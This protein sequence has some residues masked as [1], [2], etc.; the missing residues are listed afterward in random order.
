MKTDV[1]TGV[2]APFDFSGIHEEFPSLREQDIDIEVVPFEPI[3]SS[4]ASPAL[5]V[6][7]AE[8]IKVSYDR[9]DGFV[10]LHGTDT[11]SY[12]SSALGFMLENLTKPVVFTGSQ[13]PI[14][15]MRTDGRENLITAIEIAAAK[16]NKG[17]AMVPEV[18]LYF[19][20]KLFRAN[21]TMKLSAEDLS[22]FASY[23][24]PALADVGI[25]IHYNR[26]AIAKLRGKQPFGINTAL[27][28]RVMIVK[29]F[30]GMTE[31][32]F[33]SM[34]ATPDVKA[35][36]L[37]TYGS[38]NAPT[39]DWFIDAVAQTV[40]RGIHIINVTQC[41][42]GSVDMDIYETG[43]MLGGTG[44][45]SGRDIT[46]EAAVAKMMHLLG[47]GLSGSR[48]VRELARPLRGEMSE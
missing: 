42:S 30:P 6:K 41:A 5:W 22:A 26:G 46:T 17:R 36:V 32:V 15:V 18:C 20:N 3:D 31:R 47:Q 4:N 24:Y 27:D 11:M 29:I 33:R 13:I 19:Q 21:R 16:D 48:F 40:K 2:L 25:G 8:I 7:L 35:I 28:D 43:R 34:L 39:Y 38:G 1:R 14:G 23:N 44:V 12:S 10:V 45:V 37:E 9:F